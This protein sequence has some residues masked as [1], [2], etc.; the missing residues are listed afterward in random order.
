M[1]FFTPK[2]NVYNIFLYFTF[3]A[4]KTIFKRNWQNCKMSFNYILRYIS[5]EYIEICY[6]VILVYVMCE[7]SDSQQ[8]IKLN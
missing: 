4:I 8:F 3:D 2:R 6:Y 7:M 1:R 5:T